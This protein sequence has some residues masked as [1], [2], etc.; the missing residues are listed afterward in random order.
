MQVAFWHGF[1]FAFGLI[2][3]LGAQNIFIFNQGALQPRF[4]KNLP[5]IIVAG[6]CDTLLILLAVLGVSVVVLTITWFKYIMIV[7]GVIF[8]GYMGWVTWHSR[9]IEDTDDE[10]SSWTVKRQIL[11]TFSVSLLNPHAIIDT[12]GVIGT[13]SVT[14]AGSAKVAFTL[15]CILVSWLWFFILA[16]S[17]RLVGKADSKGS[18]RR[19]LNRFSAVIMWGTAIYLISSLSK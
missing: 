4:L 1:I 11:F 2:L 15:A 14:Y 5:V 3:P 13:T 10:H 8:L 18:L 9:I 17:G 19:W 12:I 7:T 16:I 6:F